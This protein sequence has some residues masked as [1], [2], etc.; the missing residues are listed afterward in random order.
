MKKIKH[1]Q[2]TVVIGLSG[3]VDSAVAA[4]LLKRQGYK[5]IGA[6]MKNFSDTKNPFTGECSY[7]EDKKM[8]RRV[9]LHLKIPF[10]VFDFERQYKKLVIEKMYSAYRNGLTPNPDISCNAIIKFPLFWKEAKKLGADYISMGHYANIKK[11]SKGYQ[12]L[13]GKD[14]LKD[15]SYFLADLTQSD[16]EHTLFPLGNLTKS[17]VRK[18]AKKNHFPNWNRHGTVGIC[19]VGQVNM[20]KFLN[21][22]I[23]SKQGS[24][25]DINNN[26]IGS[27]KGIEFYTI[28]QK[29]GEHIGINIKK[30]K[31]QAQKRFYI[32]KKVKPNTLIVAPEG[33]SL[34]FKKE[35]M[36][37]SL[38]LINP[39]DKIP[40]KLKVRIRHL[41]QL[42][43]GKLQKDRFVLDNSIQAVAPGQ[44]AVFYYKNQVIGCAEIK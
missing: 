3:G 34:L 42:Y 21:K 19:F 10:V 4:L 22:K 27:H 24:V 5:V 44:I 31:E 6:F 39:K 7:L 32:A 26:I 18:V 33:H 41:G 23:K 29:V 1:N 43:E 28:G 35:I 15:Q 14:K 16:L 36:I 13:A 20:Q 11:I 40:S 2:K 8:A 25:K 9:A 38:H 37:R 17:E 12:L 30:P